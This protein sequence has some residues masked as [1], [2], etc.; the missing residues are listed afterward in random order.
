MPVER[1]QIMPNEIDALVERLQVA[2]GPSQDLDEDIA[3]AVGLPFRQR[4]DG[5]G[6]SKG[7][8]YLEDSHGGVQIW[9]RHPPVYTSSID[10]A[11]TLYD[12]EIAAMVD[13]GWACTGGENAKFNTIRRLVISALNR[14]ARA[15]GGSDA[16]A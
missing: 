4:R 5:R 15:Q 3:Y 2:S 11:L 13:L 7:R 16:K 12:D 14:R 9:A 8:E 6:H 10:A 1:P